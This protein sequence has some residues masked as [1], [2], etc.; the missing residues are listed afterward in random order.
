MSQH[1]V[2]LLHMKNMTSFASYAHLLDF[3][4]SV[5]KLLKTGSD[6]PSLSQQVLFRGAGKYDEDPQAVAVAL[7]RWAA[8]SSVSQMSPNCSIFDQKSSTLPCVSGR[9]PALHKTKGSQASALSA[10][11]AAELFQVLGNPSEVHRRHISK[12][13]FTFQFFLW[14]YFQNERI[15]HGIKEVRLK[16]K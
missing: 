9:P 1:F 11:L 8:R 7:T 4:C 2:L 10:Y 14:V 6:M 16:M 13:C 15:S 3:L 12:C 5:S